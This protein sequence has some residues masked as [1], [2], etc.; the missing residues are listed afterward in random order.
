MVDFFAGLTEIS[1]TAHFVF[2]GYEIVEG[3]IAA[4]GIGEVRRISFAPK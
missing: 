1:T 4:D 2:M 3:R